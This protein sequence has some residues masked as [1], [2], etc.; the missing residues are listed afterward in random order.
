MMK[1]AIL[2]LIIGIAIGYFIYVKQKESN[3]SLQKIV[4]DAFPK[5]TIIEKFNTVMVCEINHRNEPNELIF[6][7]IGEAKRIK[8]EGGRIVA[9]Y[10]KKPTKRTLKKDL[11]R[12]IK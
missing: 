4:K 2:L 5:N 12:Y 11:E 1:T 8:K 7:R 9:T 6:I 3:K 10:P